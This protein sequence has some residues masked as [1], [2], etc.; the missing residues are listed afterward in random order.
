MATPITYPIGPLVKWGIRIVTPIYVLGESLL[1]GLD[2][3]EDAL[4]WRQLQCVV[5]RTPT[6]G[7]SDDFAIC[8]F[9]LLNLT[10][11][12]PDST[13]DAGD[14]AAAEAAFDTYWNAVKPLMSGTHKVKEYR[15]YTRSFA[16]VMSQTHRF[17]DSG[18]PQRITSKS[19]VG[20]AGVAAQAWQV[21]MTVTERTPWARHWGRWYM[22]GLAV[23]LS[24]SGRISSTD[25]TTQ[26][27]A[28]G[29]LLN[30]LHDAQ[31]PLVVA[32]TQADNVLSGYLL[33]VTET[34]VDDIPDVQRRR[35]PRAVVTRVR[36][37]LS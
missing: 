22:P 27:T 3:S 7:T 2:D 18:P 30:T 15:W 1:D 26:A 29:I 34:Q 24:A 10:G 11:G 32:S 17:A 25:T 14:Y 16:P 12:A 4:S 37:P 28:A 9:D 31:L 8:T 33:G 13:W 19:I 6:A 35:R 5:E 36:V 21:A 20:T 23:T